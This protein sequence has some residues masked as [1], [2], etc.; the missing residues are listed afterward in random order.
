MT[1]KKMMFNTL[2]T[3]CTTWWYKCVCTELTGWAIDGTPYLYCIQPIYC[4][5]Q[6]KYWG[7]KI[8]SYTATYLQSAGPRGW[9]VKK[10][11][12]ERV[13]SKTC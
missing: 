13:L 1:V 11:P 3:G 9:N 2:M 4:A 7:K 6:N 12:V 10:V 5:K 8:R